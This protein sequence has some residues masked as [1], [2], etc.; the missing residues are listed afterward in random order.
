[1]IY[2]RKIN[3]SAAGSRRATFWPLQELFISELWEKIRTPTRGKEPQAEYLSMKKARQDELKDVGGFVAGTLKNNRR[4]AGNVTGRDVL[5]LDLDA[6][7]PGGTNSILQ[8]VEALGCGYC[9]YSTRKHSPAAPRL[10][11]LIPLDRTATAEEYE[12]ISRKAAQLID[13]TLKPFDPST[14]EP[15]RLMYWPSVSADGEYI[16]T[17]A[18]NPLLYAD[19]MLSMYTD[20]HDYTQW[21]QVPGSKET[22]ARLAAKQEDPTQKKGVV[23]AFCRCYDIFGAMESFIPGIYAPTDQPERYTFAGGS[24]TGGAVVYDNGLY[25]FSHHA[26]DPAGGK[27]C[28][29]FDLVR[30]HLYGDLDDDAKEGTPANKLP[31]YT[32]MCKA[33]VADSTVAALLDR[34]R[35]DA[36]TGDFNNLAPTEDTDWMK[37]LARNPNTGAY[38]KTIDNVLII[39]ENDP[40]LKGRISLDTF[41]QRGI[42][43]GPYPWN[44]QAGSRIW[45]DND[46]AGMYWYLEKVYHITGQDK[47]LNALSIYGNLH[48][49]DPITD[50]LQGLSWD[51]VPRLDT[52]FIDY[53]GAADTPYT[54]AVTRKAFC[55]AVARAMSPGIKF[56]NMTI[57][58]GPQGIG[59]STLLR[60]MGRNHFSDS[61]KTFEG[62]E[63]CELI[64][65]VWIVEVGELEAMARSEIGRIKQFLSQSEDIFRQP[66]GRRT[67]LYPR[68]CVFFGTS[69]NT[70]YLRDRTGNRRF[71]PVDVGISAATKSVFNDLKENIDQLWAE[72]L[73]RWQMGEPLYLSGEAAELALQ[74]QETHREHSPREGLIRE[75]IEKP[76]PVDWGKWK[77]DARRMYWN[78]DMK[79]EGGLVPR[80]KICAAEVWCEALGGDMKMMKYSDAQ[81]ING[82][83]RNMDGWQPLKKASRFGCHGVQKGFVKV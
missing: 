17:Y 47:A 70:E 22:H 25:L 33:A 79:Y 14:F 42:A 65:G 16:F 43:T 68:R 54:R 58:S 18:D 82:V 27:L 74:E 28:N 34:E 9:I 66:Y 20:W 61:L 83:I 62:K 40:A 50:Y 29:A 55:A 78:S 12:A 64:Q 44:H 45:G 35:Y 38:D 72:A 46:D 51:G 8:A 13:P 53:L 39:L 81:E 4:K 19:G 10:R 80:D 3:I 73:I 31:S 60:Y 77:A 5:T 76:V 30:L 26:T 24:T 49:K 15:S 67:N 2:D 36:A 59:K 6:I 41:S 63:A 75:F 21:P 37:K 32:A 1:M 71:W 69:N 48:A 52:L 23:G 56:D 7:P 11:V 57:L